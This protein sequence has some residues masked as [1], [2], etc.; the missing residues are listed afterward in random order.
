MLS[1]TVKGLSYIFLG[2]L[3]LVLVFFFLAGLLYLFTYTNKILNQNNYK[4]EILYVDSLE[5]RS[6][7]YRRRQSVTYVY[8][9][10]NQTDKVKYVSGSKNE[11]T[12]E[13]TIP[14]WYIRRNK[15]RY[16][17]LYRSPQERK[18]KDRIPSYKKEMLRV[19]L[20]FNV[21]FLTFCLIYFFFRKYNHK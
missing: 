6:A 10:V 5:Y 18:F 20:K 16:S 11:I 12:I 15:S 1:D 19:F 21:P 2:M 8:G 13:N 17:I 7:S 9:T 14:I 4:Q 3:F